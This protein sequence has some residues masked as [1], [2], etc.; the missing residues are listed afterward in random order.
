MGTKKQK[1]EKDV[2]KIVVVIGKAPKEI[3]IPKVTSLNEVTKAMIAISSIQRRKEEYRIK[4]QKQIDEI[5][6]RVAVSDEEAD[7]EITVIFESIFRF[8]QENKIAL[9]NHNRIRTVKLLTGKFGWRESPSSI[10]ITNKKTVMESIQ[11]LGLKNFIRYEP[12]IDKEAMLKEPDVAK[13]INGVSIKKPEMFFIKP[14]SINEE[15]EKRLTKI[16]EE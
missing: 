8:A 3:L 2:K 10:H 11:K 5:T 6:S 15:F 9:T 13:T 16:S 12:E 4:K 1:T 7:K 14:T